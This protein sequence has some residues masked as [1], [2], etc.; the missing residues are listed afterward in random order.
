MMMMIY[1]ICGT[2]WILICFCDV[3]VHVSSGI[4]ISVQLLQCR[5][6]HGLVIKATDLDP[7]NLGSTHEL[8]AVA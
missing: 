5:S 4:C 8:L 6:N 3:S 2:V 7:V 1:A